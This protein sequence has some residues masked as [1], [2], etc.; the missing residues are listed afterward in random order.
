MWKKY[1]C[2]RCGRGYVNKDSLTRHKRL[3]CGVEPKFVCDYCSHKTK[4]KGNLLSHI[5][6]VHLTAE[7]RSE[8]EC[9]YECDKCK[10]SYVTKDSLNRHKRLECYVNPQFICDYCGHKGKQ[11]SHILS[12]I[13]KLHSQPLTYKERPQRCRREIER[14]YK[15]DICG[16][17]Y[18][19]QRSL[20]THKRTECGIEP[21]FSCDYC[22]YKSKRKC[23]LLVHIVKRHL[24]S[25]TFLN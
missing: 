2:E 5:L 16:R 20:H 23:D 22:S 15:C 7:K 1:Q 3:E 13:I 18:A 17:S 8:L 6:R 19:H 9:L 14:K 12:H 24:K 25:N 11:K 4:H 21:K 10:R